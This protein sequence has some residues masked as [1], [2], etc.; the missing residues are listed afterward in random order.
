M[1][2]KYFLPIKIERRRMHVCHL[3][4]GEK[5]CGA[6]S[7][8][9]EENN[10]F[11]IPGDAKFIANGG[12]DYNLAIGDFTN[13]SDYRVIK[14]GNDYCI[15]FIHA[16]ND[17]KLPDA[18]M[19]KKINGE[20]S[21]SSDID[22]S[23]APC[24]K[25]DTAFA[26]RSFTLFVRLL[27]LGKEDRKV[28]VKETYSYGFQ[29][30]RCKKNEGGFI[31]AAIDFGSEASQV[32][33]KSGGGMP[34]KV[35]LVKVFNNFHNYKETDF[36]Q[37][38]KE[39]DF[40]FKSV[41]FINTD[42]SNK[43]FQY[44]DKPYINAEDSFIQ[45]LKPSNAT[46]NKDLRILPNLKLIECLPHEEHKKAINVKFGENR[47]DY[48]E[49]DTYDLYHETVIE[50]S[51][52]MILSHILHAILDKT[53]SSKKQKYLFLTLLMPNVYPQYKVYTLIKNLYSD[54][55]TIRKTAEYNTFEG[56]EIQM[57]SESD[58][59]FLGAKKSGDVD[60][61]WKIES[62]ND[63]HFLIIDAGKGTTDFSILKQIS[64]KRF[65]SV[66]RTGIP[67]SGH[68]L[69]YAFF[70]ALENLLKEK[71]IDLLSIIKKSERATVL[72]FMEKL[73]KLK[74]AYND[75]KDE[76]NKDDINNY[77]ET[78][79]INLS[80]INMFLD[81]NFVN[82]NLQIA[83]TNKTLTDKIDELLK[84]IM[85][86]VELSKIKEFKKVVFT[87]RA[88][89]FKPFYEAL[90]N[91]LKEKGIIK[92]WESA[93]FKNIT[94][95]DD[96]SKTICIKGAFIMEESRINENSELIGTPILE[97]KPGQEEKLSFFEN[98]LN[99][100]KFKSKSEE[101]IFTE[102][103][104]IDSKHESFDI[105]IS[106]RV[107]SFDKNNVDANI[108]DKNEDCKCMFTGDGFII[109]FKTTF[110]QFNE[111]NAAQKG[112]TNLTWQSLF[113]FYDLNIKESQ[114]NQQKD[115]NGQKVPAV[116]QIGTLI[117]N[118]DNTVLKPKRIK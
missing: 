60:I 71:N 80:E 30:H 25:L 54:F 77:P 7:F 75:N 10:L 46:H 49:Y 95:D 50:S 99:I 6:F 21:I 9:I 115:S 58:A 17:E 86:R 76:K 98:L 90:E 66:F 45:I 32:S 3:N 59:A 83:G 43:R 112:S 109:Q 4:K 22:K 19:P 16:E 104:T 101:N 26:S 28:I 18:E 11:E 72:N 97:L 102:G 84:Q 12:Y 57:I 64:E 114:E 73:E 85:S 51:L 111:V 53:K 89:K 5:N 61:E 117:E 20:I 65:E 110:K 116:S 34:Q 41:F 13:N 39:N 107:Q 29:I 35:N 82:A 62:K 96:S 52:R 27:L 8:I 23:N 33:F 56:I 68:V 37:K 55:E 118:A 94:P 14:D 113:P 67:A 79:G 92:N 69:T 47:P 87:G 15:D 44:A 105:R 74:I 93:A 48:I 81:S 88:F 91:K 24:V 78:E 36:W 108:A 1:V 63:A 106:G 103:I 2:D 31:E 100:F 40:L 42:N 70:E 38:D